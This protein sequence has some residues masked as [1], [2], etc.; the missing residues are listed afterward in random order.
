MVINYESADSMFCVDNL[1]MVYIKHYHTAYLA[2][3]S[4]CEFIPDIWIQEFPTRRAIKA[5]NLADAVKFLYFYQGTTN[6]KTV[7]AMGMNPVKNA[8]NKNIKNPFNKITQNP[9]MWV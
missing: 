8:I 7:V 6:S 5:W 2:V 1:G 9:S 4:G 3:N